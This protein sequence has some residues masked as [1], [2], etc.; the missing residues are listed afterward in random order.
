M[1]KKLNLNINN[2]LSKDNIKVSKEEYSFKRNQS[3]ENSITKKS[4]NSSSL[5]EIGEKQNRKIG[6]F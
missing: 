1:K 3:K 6:I 2:Y 4:I 5:L